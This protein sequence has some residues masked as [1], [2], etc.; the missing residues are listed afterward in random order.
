MLRDD[1]Q[2]PGER[3]RKG[4]TRDTSRQGLLRTHARALAVAQMKMRGAGAGRRGARPR[5]ALS[6]S[7]CAL[8]AVLDL[9]N[10]AYAQVHDLRK[11]PFG[12]ADQVLEWF[13]EDGDGRVS[14]SEFVEKMNV[15]V[16]G[17]VGGVGGSKASATSASAGRHRRGGDNDFRLEARLTH[18]RRVI[19]AAREDLVRAIEGGASTTAIAAR[20]PRR[21][22]WW[23]RRIVLAD[24]AKAL[25]TFVE[26]FAHLGHARLV[27]HRFLELSE[28]AARFPAAALVT[29]AGVRALDL[30]RAQIEED[31]ATLIC[32]WYKRGR[33]SSGGGGSDG[34]AA[35]SSRDDGGTDFWSMTLR[36]MTEKGRLRARA[37]ARKEMRARAREREEHEKRRATEQVQA[38]FRSKLAERC[39]K[40]GAS[41]QG[42]ADEGDGGGAGAGHASLD[43][44]A[45]DVD[46]DL[47]RLHESP[48]ELHRR[49]MR[50]AQ[51]MRAKAAQERQK[52][53]VKRFMESPFVHDFL[54]YRRCKRPQLADFWSGPGGSS[55]GAAD[56]VVAGK[57]AAAAAETEHQVEAAQGAAEQENTGNAETNG[58]AGE[59][60]ASPRIPNALAKRPAPQRPWTSQGRSSSSSSS[61]SGSSGSNGNGFRNRGSSSRSSRG[62]SINQS[63]PK[64]PATATGGGGGRGGVRAGDGGGGGTIRFRKKEQLQVYSRPM[65][66]V[67]RQRVLRAS[68]ASRVSGGGGMSMIYVSNKLK[69]KKAVLRMPTPRQND[70]NNS[71]GTRNLRLLPNGFESLG[72]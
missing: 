38:F 66:S 4:G 31:A 20:R 32:R 24:V 33:S 57:A 58:V 40:E 34:S 51:D 50:E 22:R 6:A 27:N 43:E 65:S 16:P 60:S 44:E 5:S 1:F 70:N 10:A 37:R 59:Y 48:F 62:T 54:G 12:C 56:V 13:D 18:M 55:A 71:G 36:K 42:E 61:S 53:D 69:E 49:K 64:R 7:D 3:P 23:Q 45:G 25:N 68:K 52:M 39:R 2:F 19:E 46:E 28:C 63:R 35:F 11:G 41:G 26:T 47:L 67:K 15:R 14:A 21:W 9:I 17:G 30:L 72:L 8:P 29:R